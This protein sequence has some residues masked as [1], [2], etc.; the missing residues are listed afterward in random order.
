MRVFVLLTAGAL[1]L[2]DA[3]A[4]ADQIVSVPPADGA[5][6]PAASPLL[7]PPCRDSFWGGVLLRCVPRAEVVVPADDVLLQNQIRGL[8]PPWR[9]PYVQVFTW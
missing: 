8:Q 4:A 6:P 3:A 7:L 5:F 1:L 2:A 9:K